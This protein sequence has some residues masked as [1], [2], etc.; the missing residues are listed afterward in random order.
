MKNTKVL[1]MIIVIAL[2]M[3]LPSYAE[4]GKIDIGPFAVADYEDFVDAVSSKNAI[5]DVTFENGALNIQMAAPE[6]GDPNLTFDLSYF[7]NGDIDLDTYKVVA[8]NVK[9]STG[10]GNGY[11][12]FDTDNSPGLAESKMITGTYADTTDWQTITFDLTSNSNT[13]GNLTTLRLDP[14][15]VCKDVTYQI[16]WIAFFKTVDD[17]KAFTGDFSPVATPVP[18]PTPEPTPTPEKTEAPATSAPTATPEVKNDPNTKGIVIAAV[19]A[20]A[21]IAIVA[22][23]VVL[24]KKK[25]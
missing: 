3:I 13:N 11:I 10:G 24:V 18:S 8:F 6:T 16:K 12:Y 1:I 25:K 15:N 19:S 2:T 9:I 5:D 17:A 20:V 22:I 4:E 14:F 23:I 7:L 21:G